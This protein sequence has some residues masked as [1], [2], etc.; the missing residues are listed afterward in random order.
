V[1][2]LRHVDGTF[3]TNPDPDTVIEPKQVIIAVGTDDDL[4]RLAEVSP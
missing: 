1:L 2:A 4:S 3:T